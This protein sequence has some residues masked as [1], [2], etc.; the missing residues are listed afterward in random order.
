[1]TN[2]YYNNYVEL[3]KA[4]AFLS[5]AVDL[6]IYH[7]VGKAPST[8]GT[9]PP[10]DSTPTAHPGCGGRFA[11]KRKNGANLCSVKDCDNPARA[12]GYCIKH[13]GRWYKHGNPNYIASLSGK[14]NPMYKHG[15]YCEPSYCEC[16][17]EK[18][19]RSQMCSVCAG[20]SFPI[21]QKE[22][23][24]SKFDISDDQI[25]EAISTSKD[26]V[27]TAEMLGI[28]RSELM[29]RIETIELIDTSHFIAGR[30]RPLAFDSMFVKNSPVTG[31]AVRHHILKAE[32]KEYMCAECGMLPVWNNKPLVLQLHHI[33][34]D[35]KDHRL[36]NL[37][38]LCPNCHTQTDTYTG[39][40]GKGGNRDQ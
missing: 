23:D 11:M 26:Y 8:I 4:G 20:I 5:S 38:W 3:S 25:K 21:G 29:R 12:R 40:N 30:G 2:L 17:R 32:L 7:L 27:S 28:S 39:K 14:N 35:S 10:L 24:Y 13:Y 31:S 36:E 34:G 19:P 16:G 9:I 37:A 15:K 22:G 33:N 18:D 1:M 6:Q